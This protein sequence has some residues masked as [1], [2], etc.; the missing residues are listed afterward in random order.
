MVQDEFRRYGNPMR[1]PI[2]GDRLVALFFLLPFLL[3]MFL[4]VQLFHGQVWRWVVMGAVIGVPVI[5]ITV[6]FPCSQWKAKPLP[7]SSEWVESR[8]KMET[9]HFS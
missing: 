5:T 6:L 8:E 3:L 4:E 7:P 1:E 2:R 9:S